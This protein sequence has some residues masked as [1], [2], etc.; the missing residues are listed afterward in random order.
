M[1][2]DFS[3]R[4]TH[5]VLSVH[6]YRDPLVIS[7]QENVCHETVED[8]DRERNLMQVFTQSEYHCDFTED[9]LLTCV[10]RMEQWLKSGN[11]PPKK[12]FRAEQ[13]FL[14]AFTPPA[15]PYEGGQRS[16]PK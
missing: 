15:W 8:A 1:Y 11:K 5:P 3:G 4:I 2:A 12:S 13:G 9:Q 10:H 6:T 16:I 7:A 14:Q